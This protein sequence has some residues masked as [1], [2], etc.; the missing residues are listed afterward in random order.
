MRSA[1]V[2]TPMGSEGR[3]QTIA[4]CYF[5]KNYLTIFTSENEDTSM[6]RI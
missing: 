3:M 1:K 5:K 4:L 6:K 2:C